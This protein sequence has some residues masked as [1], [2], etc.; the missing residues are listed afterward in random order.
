MV[1]LEYSVDRPLSVFFRL[2]V[3]HKVDGVFPERE[4]LVKA[5]CDDLGSATPRTQNPAATEVTFLKHD[6]S[7]GTRLDRICAR[8]P[9]K[10][11][12]IYTF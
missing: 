12:W 5:F 10:A 8:S 9:R 4:V 7:V 2:N 6:R 3:K 11:L 1:P